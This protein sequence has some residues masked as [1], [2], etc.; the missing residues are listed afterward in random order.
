[1]ADALT[2]TV[3]GRP[4]SWERATP[5]ARGRAIS[6]KGYREAKALHASHALRARQLLRWALDAQGRYAVDVQ[7]WY[8]DGRHGDIDRVQSL[9]LDALQG[10]VYADDRQVKRT[11]ATVGTDREAPR[12]VV[13]VRALSAEEVEHIATA[14]MERQLAEAY[15]LLR[16]HV[17]P[18][19]CESGCARVACLAWR[20]ADG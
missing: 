18:C 10:V 6:S 1:M 5:I 15:E 8:P 11:T 16:C 2:Y 14:S 13:T 20:A 17:A 3:L 12:T 4:S 9:T 19:D 7:A